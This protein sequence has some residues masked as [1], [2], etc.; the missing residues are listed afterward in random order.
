M[1]VSLLFNCLLILF[2]GVLFNNLFNILWSTLDVLKTEYLGLWGIGIRLL[3]L[4][5]FVMVFF[6]ANPLNV[7]L[8]DLWDSSFIFIIAFSLDDFFDE[9]LLSFSINLSEW[10]FTLLFE[11]FFELFELK[12]IFPSIISLKFEFLSSSNFFKLFTPSNFIK[13]VLFKLLYF[14]LIS[15]VSLESMFL[16][17]FIAFFIASFLFSFNIL[18]TSSSSSKAKFSSPIIFFKTKSISSSFLFFST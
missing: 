14:F 7:F 2:D 16:L 5:L 12:L 15:F 6:F 13:S 10:N 9:F 4:L 8:F 18:S 11:F 3:L 1:L 17:F